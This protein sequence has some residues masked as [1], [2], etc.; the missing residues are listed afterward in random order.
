MLWLREEEGEMCNGVEQYEWEGSMRIGAPM[1]NSHS[2]TN[3][4]LCV[5]YPPMDASNE[6]KTVVTQAPIT[7]LLP[8]PPNSNIGPY[9]PP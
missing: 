7:L 8:P 3:T 9:C 6:T 2:N 5:N 4:T 1:S